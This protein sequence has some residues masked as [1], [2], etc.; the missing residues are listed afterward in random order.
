VT[1]SG[2]TYAR[3]GERPGVGPQRY[4]ATE[5]GRTGSVEDLANAS[6]RFANGSSLLLDASYSLHAPQ[7]RLSVSVHGTLGGA[8]VEPELLLATERHGT[9]VNL[10]PQIEHLSF[11]LGEGFR[12]EIGNFVRACLG[13]EA[14]LA[15]VQDGVQVTRMVAA[16]YASAAAG[17]EVRLGEG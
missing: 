3:L 9:M 13:R 7:D 6:I 10:V 5:V 2:N 1:V 14:V 16:T 17:R 11:D 8:D 4:R 12:G 15:P